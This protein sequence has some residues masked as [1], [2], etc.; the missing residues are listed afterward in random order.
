VH[1]LRIV[2]RLAQAAQAFACNYQFEEKR[3]SNLKRSAKEHSIMTRRVRLARALGCVTE[4]RNSLA[5][6]RYRK[7]HALSGTRVRGEPRQ[8]QVA[9]FSS[10]EQLAEV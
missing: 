5:L 4:K 3:R 6:G 1:E 9:A 2:S 7:V 8:S 10:R